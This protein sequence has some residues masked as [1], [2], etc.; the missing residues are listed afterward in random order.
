MKSKFCERLGQCFANRVLHNENNE[1][2]RKFNY[3]IKMIICKYVA[4]LF[5][6]SVFCIREI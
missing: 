4:Y 3:D 6:S 5:L 2:T 1:S